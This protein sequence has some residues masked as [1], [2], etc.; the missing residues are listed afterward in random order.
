MVIISKYQHK[1]VETCVFWPTPHLWFEA[2]RRSF[3]ATT[4]LLPIIN[5]FN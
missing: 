5:F 1:L 2:C 4:F 3:Y